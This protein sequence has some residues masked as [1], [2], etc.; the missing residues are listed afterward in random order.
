MIPHTDILGIIPS[1]SHSHHLRMRTVCEY[2]SACI[3]TLDLA[4]IQEQN[5]C[6]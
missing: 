4:G 3:E 2:T 1:L 6:G 5:P